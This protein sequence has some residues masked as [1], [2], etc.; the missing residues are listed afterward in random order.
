MPYSEH[1]HYRDCSAKGQ[2]LLPLHG[3][4]RHVEERPI[5]RNISLIARSANNRFGT[6]VLRARSSTGR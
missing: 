3:S 1:R 5:L 6:A 4:Q 2:R